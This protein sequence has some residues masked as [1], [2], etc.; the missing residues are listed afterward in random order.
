MYVKT[1][2]DNISDITIHLCPL[3][4]QV[5]IYTTGRMQ[6]HVKEHLESFK[7][8]KTPTSIGRLIPCSHELIR[9]CKRLQ[10]AIKWD[11]APSID[12]A[13]E[14]KQAWSETEVARVIDAI[15]ITNKEQQLAGIDLVDKRGRTIQIKYDGRGG[16]GHGCTGNLYYELAEINIYNTHH[17]YS[18]TSAIFEGYFR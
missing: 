4:R 10:D 3:A 5:Y 2:R 8:I 15:I 18:N 9:T 13:P 11:D 7:E 17:T 14:D 12:A 6:E 1:E 16:L